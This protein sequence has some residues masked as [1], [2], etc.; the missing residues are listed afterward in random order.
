MTRGNAVRLNLQ[1]CSFPRP[2]GV[3]ESIVRVWGEGI[4][5][6]T[7]QG[8]PL[9]ADVRRWAARKPLPKLPPEA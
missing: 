7:K 6:E 5:S 4:H 8:G 2:S 1:A 3:C 9:R